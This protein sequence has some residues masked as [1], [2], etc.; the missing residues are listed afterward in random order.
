MR[1]LVTGGAGYIG[2]HAVR[3]LARAGHD[4]LILDDL[5]TGFA[6]LARGHHLVKAD[7]GDAAAVAPLLRGVD[8]VMHFAAFAWVG[9]ATTHPCKYFE[10][11]VLKGLRFLHAVLDAGVRHFIFS[12]SCTLYGETERVPITE[13]APRN[14][15]NVYGYTKLV[16]EHALEAY[17]AAYG[18]RF[19]SLRYFNAAGADAGGEIGEMHDPETHL[20]PIALD[21]AAGLR[22]QLDVY[23]DDYSTPDGTCIR[24]Y[25]HVTDLARA[26]VMAMEHL[27]RGG[28]SGF[29]NLGTGAGHSVKKVVAA[30]ARVTKR[31]VKTRIAPRRAGDPPVLVADASKARDVLGWTPQFTLDDIVATAWRW[32]RTHLAAKAAATSGGS[33]R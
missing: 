29:F 25:V 8:A 20:I 22:P 24:D 23:G 3:E 11:N 5:S 4:A 26:H 13:D 15:V 1:V 18:L 10:N 9:E 30:I 12:S 2:S 31:D 28:D 33:S 6:Q 17:A 19:A 27:A 14:P 7:M 32:Q 16:F 21:V